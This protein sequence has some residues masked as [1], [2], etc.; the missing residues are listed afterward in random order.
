[1]QHVDNRSVGISGIAFARFYLDVH[2]E[3]RLVI[4]EK[5]SEIGGTWSKCRLWLPILYFD[6]GLPCSKARTFDTFW[7]Q[8]PLR[9]TSFADAPLTLPEDAPRLYDTF[10]ARYV[11]QYLEDY[12]RDHVYADRPLL[13]RIW[14]KTEVASVKKIE[15][16][17]E[18]SLIGSM[19]YSIRCSKLAV[20]S[21][22][23]SQAN[24]PDFPHHPDWSS[25]I[26]HHRNFGI[27][28]QTLLSATSSYKHITVLG[29]GKS[30]ADM[31]YAAVN[32]NPNLQI[33]WIVRK[34]GEGPGYFLHAAPNG[35]YRNAAEPMLSRNA[36]QMNPSGFRT[37]LPEFQSLHREESGRV[38]V[39]ERIRA[40]DERAKSWANYRGREG[41]LPNF[42]TLEPKRS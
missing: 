6:H 10:P 20:A 14:L 19:A 13:D 8:S 7:T 3:T 15:G 9:T 40:A 17:W 27:H 36:T 18:V 42:Q 24:L 34:K 33:N 26:L 30:A 41:A 35:R 11:S 1:M 37:M 22:L 23:T 25:P 2:P 16:G 31:V 29:G 38:T 12:V 28:S 4:I 21:G 5:E 39:N 32:T